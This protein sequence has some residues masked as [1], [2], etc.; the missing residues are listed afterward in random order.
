MRPRIARLLA[1]LVSGAAAMVFITAAADAE[2]LSLEI[3]T[4]ALT[5]YVGNSGMLYH[6]KPVIQTDMLLTLPKGFYVDVL[7]SFG[8][9]GTGMSSDLGDEGDLGLGWRG[10]VKGL[11]LDVGA[12]YL[13]F[14]DIFK[15][16]GDV[17]SPYVEVS[18]TFD[19]SK[20]H[21][22]TPYL[23]TEVI[24][25]AKGTIPGNGVWLFGGVRH[26]WQVS[27]AFAASQRLGLVYDDG[28]Y[29]AESGLLGQYRLKLSWDL[30]KSITFDVLSLKVSF[31]LTTFHDRETQAVVGAGFTLRF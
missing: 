23:R 27:Q 24:F 15:A 16:R 10:N 29:D 31:P 13:D 30:T 9:D 19:I 20:S 26:K 28:A 5:K 7:S 22:L 3:S 4:E 21:S 12:Y 25:P 11:D 14:V 18:K 17:I 6:D 8:L 2:G 1:V